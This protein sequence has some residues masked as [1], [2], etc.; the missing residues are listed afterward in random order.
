M[1][2]QLLRRDRLPSPP[3]PRGSFG[4]G[5][6][7]A[8]EA[9]RLGFLL[10]LRAEYGPVARLGPRT[11]VIS[12]PELALRVLRDRSGAFAVLENFLQ[13]RVDASSM[14][15]RRAP[16]PLL[17]AALRPGAISAVQSL[18]ASRLRAEASALRGDGA[19]WFDPVPVLERAFSGAMAEFCFGSGSDML[20]IRIGRLLDELTCVIGNPFALPA[21]ARSPVRRR[22][23]AQYR[24]LVAEVV[25]A[26]ER[27]TAAGAMCHDLA[28]AIVA[29]NHDAHPVGRL[30]DMLIG[31]LLAAYR[32]PAAAGGWLLMLTADHPAL[33]SRLHPPAATDAS[34]QSAGEDLAR[35][36]VMEALRLYPP[37]W[38][39]A[40]TATAPVVLGDWEFGRGHNFLISP[41]VI[42][43][44][45]TL[46]R[47]AAHFLPERWQQARPDQAAFLSFGSGIHLCPGRSLAVAMLTTTLATLTHDHTIDRSADSVVADPRSTL[48]PRGLQIRLRPVD[49]APAFFAGA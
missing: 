7:A 28:G 23:D 14:G 12:A 45:A 36:M 49:Q 38:M 26:L 6:L 4:A 43:R 18:I 25:A 21:R 35:R 44:D 2:T 46:F 9:D 17:N 20:A 48:L 31:A 41:Y 24:A 8:Y 16:R 19:G 22:I 3:G 1:P 37:T 5:N 32:V 11:T 15:E 40:R 39:L 29:H 27:R 47:D 30:A 13:Q 34:G 10:Q 33:Q 42:H